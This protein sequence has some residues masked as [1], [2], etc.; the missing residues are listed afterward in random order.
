MEPN[1]NDL[2]SSQASATSAKRKR[3][4]RGRYR[5]LTLEKKTM[6]GQFKLDIEIPDYV[7][8]AVGENARSMVNFCGYVVRT[9]ALMDAGDWSDVFAKYGSS[10]WLQV[11]NKFNIKDSCTQ[12][13]RLQAFATDVMQRLYRLWK[14]RLHYYYKEC[15]NTYEERLENPPP[16]FPVASWRACCATFNSDKFKQR[17]ARN[18]KNRNSEKWCKH[19]TGNLSFPEVE[20]I[21]TKKMM[22]CFLP[23]MLY[24]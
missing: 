13:L 20:H 2:N 4:Q 21:L 18:S 8:Q 17:S 22:V 3:G 12:E 14:C 11:K 10:M 15:G 6:G 5:S 19:T 24:G 16:D 7:L 1:R 9:I 23:R